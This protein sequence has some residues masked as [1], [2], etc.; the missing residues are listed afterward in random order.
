[1]ERKIYVPKNSSRYADEDREPPSKP[2]NYQ[3]KMKIVSNGNFHENTHDKPKNTKVK[4]SRIEPHL[5][6]LQKYSSYE[7]DTLDV[8]DLYYEFKEMEKHLKSMVEVF[9]IYFSP[10]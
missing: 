6:T 10:L 7:W 5:H 2:T 9:I 8:N 1:M 3:K 4:N